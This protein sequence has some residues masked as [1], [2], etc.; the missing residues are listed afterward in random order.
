MG[1]PDRRKCRIANLA[2]TRGAND[3]AVTGESI[4]PIPQARVDVEK[5]A[6]LSMVAVTKSEDFVKHCD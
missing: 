4:G 2:A 1:S 3:R 6:G 5:I